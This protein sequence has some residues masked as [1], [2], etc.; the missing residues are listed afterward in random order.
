M[1]LLIS[2]VRVDVWYTAKGVGPLRSTNQ[3][4]VLGCLVALLIGTT[5]GAGDPTAN[6][7]TEPVINVRT[8]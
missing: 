7:R 3:L 4:C 8:K 5:Q 2:F 6:A 1:G